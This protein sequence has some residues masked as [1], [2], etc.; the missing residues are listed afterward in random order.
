VIRPLTDRVKRLIAPKGKTPTALTGQKAA[1]SLLRGDWLYWPSLAF[2]RE[3][4]AAHDFRDDFPIIQDLGVV[5]DIIVDDGV[6]VYYPTLAFRYRRHSASASSSALVDGRRL[7]DEARYLNLA[8]DLI[9]AKGWRKAA[10]T[11]RR[12]TISRL[13]ALSL[14]PGALASR[15][16]S[17]VRMLLGHVFGG[18]GHTEAREST[19][20]K[21]SD[22]S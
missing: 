8:A 4:L 6:L 18:A 9:K 11:A 2:R 3:T 5:I 10:R 14:V 15:N 19:K 21:E 16:G 12:H 13:Q 20:T 22:G 1:T 7:S 17:G